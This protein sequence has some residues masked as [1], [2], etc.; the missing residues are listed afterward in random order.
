MDLCAELTLPSVTNNTRCDHQ[1]LKMPFGFTLTEILI[2]MMILT[3]ILAF[4]VPNYNQAKLRAYEKT[5]TGQ[6]QMLA[7]AN[8]MYMARNGFFLDGSFNDVAPVNA[9]LNLYLLLP[10]NTTFSYR[11]NTLL[12][13]LATMTNSGFTLRISQSTSSPCCSAGSCPTVGVCP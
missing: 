7:D 5:M 2:V 6:L 3:T 9:G 4:A 1:R 12:D 11:R 8:K 10:E 13:Y